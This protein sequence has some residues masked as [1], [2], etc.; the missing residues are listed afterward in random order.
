[1][2]HIIGG[3]HFR[4]CPFLVCTLGRFIARSLG[5]FPT[6]PS[7]SVRQ[8]QDRPRPSLADLFSVPPCLCG[9]SLC[10]A[11]DLFATHL[12]T[13]SPPL[14]LLSLSPS[15]QPPTFPRNILPRPALYQW[16]A[17]TLRAT[18]LKGG[19]S[20]A[21]RISPYA[22]AL[23][24]RLGRA[25]QQKDKCPKMSQN[26]P[27][28]RGA[29]PLQLLD[30]SVRFPKIPE[31]SRSAN[32]PRPALRL[33]PRGSEKGTVKGIGDLLDRSKQPKCT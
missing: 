32:R 8:A 3:G 9:S 16:P 19:M 33:F 12:V 27:R 5:R 2:P 1:M 25:K 10:F 24:L 17:R 13:L 15:I 29:P 23:V 4:F 11:S 22:T 18:E 20:C 14:P 28:N 21:N 31:N 6:H 30:P 26:V 7:P